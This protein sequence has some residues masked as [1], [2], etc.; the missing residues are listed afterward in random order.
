[1]LKKFAFKFWMLSMFAVAL[2]GQAT[3]STI[4][5]LLIDP[6]GAAVPNVKVELKD[7]ATAAMRTTE[8]TSEGIFRFNSIQPGTYS[9]RIEAQGFKAYA[10]SGIRLASSETRDLGTLSMV[11]GGATESVTVEAPT[12]AVQTSSSEKG[13]LVEAAQLSNVALKGRDLFGML[14]LIPGVTGAT[15]GDT[16]GTGL[17]GAIN[18][19]GNKNFTVD[20][21]TDV[22][23][24]SNNNVHF[25]PNMDSI[26]EIRVLT[27]A[28]AAEYG[29]NANGT[30][31]VITKGGGRQFHGSAWNNWRHEEL[32]ANSFFNNRNKTPK[33]LY[34]FDIFGFSV[35]GPVYI[36]KKWNTSKNRLFFFASQEYTRQKPASTVTYFKMPTAAEVGG[37][38]SGSTTSNGA[39]LVIRDPLNN[40]T[41]FPGNRIDPARI[42]S[43]GLSFLKFLPSPNY[44]ESDPA[45]QYS[46]N[47]RSIATPTHPRRNDIIRMDLLLTS[48]LTSFFR[49]GHDFDTSDT[50]NPNYG[51]LNSKGTRS[52]VIFDHPNSGHGYAVGITYAVNPT[53][54]NEFN[55][56]KGW[57]TWDYYAKDQAQ[58]ARSQIPGL[59]SWND[60]SKLSDPLWYGNY[61]PYFTFAGGTL[62]GAPAFGNSGSVDTDP[63]S[64]WN[65]LYS[66]SD[67]ISKVAG[68]HNLKAGIYIERNGKNQGNGNYYTGNLSFGSSSTS[69][70]DTGNG[71]ANAL[72]GLVQSYQEGTKTIYNVWFTNVEPFIQDN[73]KV[74]RRLTIDVGIRLY[75]QTPY[76]DLN[77]TFAAFYQESVDPGK[78]PRLYTYGYDANHNVIAVDPKDPTNV[79]PKAYAGLYVQN[80][81]GAVIGDPANGWKAP[82]AGQATY[83]SRTI[84]PAVRAGFAWDVFGAG[85]TAVR[86]G[87]GQFY[88]RFDNN[89]VFQMSGLPP[90]GYIPQVTYLTLDQLATSTPALGPRAQSNIV[91]GNVPIEGTLQANIGIQQ[92]LP[93]GT[94]LETSYVGAF[95]RHLGVQYDVN[96]IGLFSQYDPKNANPTNPATPLPDNFLRPISGMGSIVQEEWAGSSNYNSLQVS[97]NRRFSHGLSFGLAYTFSKLITVA[98]QSYYF[99]SK[100]RFRGPTGAPHLLV[101]NYVYEV[102]GLGAKLKNKF[103]G[104]FTDKWTISGIT[105]VSS[106]TWSSASFSYNANVNQTGSATEGPN[107]F[108]GIGTGARI[109]VL[110]NPMINSGDKTFF[111]QFDT[112]AFSA[113]TPCSATYQSL[114]CFGNGGLNYMLGPGWTNWDVTLSKAIPIGLGERRVLRFRAEAYNLP[115]HAE[116]NAMGTAA[117]FN[118][119]TGALITTGS[120]FGQLT[121]TRNPRQMALTLRFEF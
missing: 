95:R 75:G 23:A 27:S 103:I 87:F 96:H 15:G 53:V 57:N 111:Q 4:V 18:G 76:K 108:T 32:N 13:A 66:F 42:S 117:T 107:L 70:L 101:F 6:S 93:F 47:Y 68:T 116:F 9:L 34:R 114:A 19:G 20:G 12:Q 36:P 17:A 110:H 25:E 85:R 84:T 26:A 115:N 44:V 82:P 40:N 72:L 16:T 55:F 61:L 8:T 56:G 45:L 41:P 31:S 94:V 100:T 90:V 113:P 120:N 5:G 97:A 51:V 43:T 59:K 78:M 89:Q 2:F 46:R 33:S 83:S 92:R 86:G 81:S 62:P 54:V 52:P 35:G 11:L 102:P 30:I 28:Y 99:D 21:V 119:A 60:L 74:S 50:F 29:R 65:D 1:M 80:A 121:G 58:L 37:D 91:T 24:G 38:F 88:N 112:S 3:S 105:T 77:N 104:A 98:N 71:Y 10:Q 14:Q 48:K 7:D 22:D 109:N 118:L 63:R 67:N 73:W 49:Y 106:G 64:S 79:K 39:L 69:P